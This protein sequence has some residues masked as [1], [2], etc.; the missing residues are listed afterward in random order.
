M[1]EQRT[2]LVTGAT[3]GLGRATAGLLAATPG[4]RVLLGARDPDAGRR[5]ATELGPHTGVLPLD[6]ADLASV[7][8]AAASAAERGPLDALLL[9]AGVQQIRADRASADG[10]ELTFA[11]NHLGHFLLTQE[12][13]P[14]LAPG[15]RVVVVSSGT[16]FGT[17]RKSGPFPGPRWADPRELARPRAESG[18][19]A[20]ATSKLANVYFGRELAGRCPQLSVVVYDPGLMPV[21]GLA[22]SYPAPA[23]AL[24]SALA[25]LLARLPFAQTPEQAAAQ[26]AA[27]VT[28]P[29]GR[30]G[31]YV[32]RDAE[33]PS[34]P[35]STDPDRARELWEV[36]AELVAPA[37]VR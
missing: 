35:E 27:L 10:H 20:Y 31:R 26:L 15:A 8:A 11:V 23:R 17:S 2:A 19:R 4:W 37:P 21:T 30:S 32:E 34:S 22:R 12:L 24:Y 28:G 16:H 3:S 25:P 33:A 7:R 36:S 5:V 13:L 9:V 1:D 14:H 6:L 29:A 18:Q